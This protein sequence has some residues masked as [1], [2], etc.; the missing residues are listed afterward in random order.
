MLQGGP[1]P[2]PPH[3][4]NENLSQ[5]CLGPSPLENNYPSDPLGKL[6]WIRECVC[7]LLKRVKSR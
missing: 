1:D 6:F 7:P 5:I 3:L 2:P 4:E